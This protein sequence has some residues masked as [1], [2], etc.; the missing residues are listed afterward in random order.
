MSFISPPDFEAPTDANGDNVYVVIVQASDGS[1]TNLH[2]LLVTVTNVNEVPVTLAGDYNNSGTVDAAD[3]VVWRNSLGTSI[4]LPNDT[5]P[6]SVTQADYNLWRANF[7]RSVPASAAST[8]EVVAQADGRNEAA[9]VV[10]ALAGSDRLKA[11][12]RTRDERPV[13]FR[14][15]R[16]DA[17]VIPSL[18]DRALQAWLISIP[19]GRWSDSDAQGDDVHPRDR[20]NQERSETDDA[21]DMAFAAL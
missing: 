11:E 8:V 14:S 17:L 7:G 6:G 18:H 21:L 1:F 4:V 19:T 13:G 15:I 12:L 5:T 9:L 10:P 16:R 20:E 2:V 3:Y